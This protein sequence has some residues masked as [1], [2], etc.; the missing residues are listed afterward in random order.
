[1]TKLD[2]L[3]RS[4]PDARDIVDELTTREV[5]LN[6]GGS[7]YDPTDPV[8]RH[9]FNVLAMVD[10]FESDLIRM[11]TRALHVIDRAD[12][13][14]AAIRRPAGQRTPAGGFSTSRS[15]ATTFDD[16]WRCASADDVASGPLRVAAIRFQNHPGVARQP[17][18]PTRLLTLAQQ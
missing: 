13:L 12:N 2:R 10:E 3:A 15:P 5:K 6:L 4:L 16:Q 14:R 18:P 7:V 1:M 8:G 11:R 17:G 9:L